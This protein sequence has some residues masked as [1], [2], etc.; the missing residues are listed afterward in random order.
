MKILD[1]KEFWKAVKPLFSSKSISGYKINLAG[2]A[3]HIKT[4]M[5]ISGSGKQ[6]FLKYSIESQDS[7]VLKFWSYCTK[8]WRSNFKSHGEI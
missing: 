4:E 6:L 2:N 5:K 8:H 7:L 3:E 1:N